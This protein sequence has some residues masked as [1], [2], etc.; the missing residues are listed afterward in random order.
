MGMTP[1]RRDFVAMMLG[2]P[3]AYACSRGS[4]TRALPPGSL[5]DTG[6]ARAHAAIRDGAVPTV[7]TWRKQPVVIV[8]GGVAGLSAAWELRLFGDGE[9]SRDFCFIDNC[10]EAN[11]LA[12]TAPGA[13]G[14]VFNV[15]CGVRTTLLDVIAELARIVGKK[16]TPV[17]EPARPGDIKHSLAD[18]TQART[19]LGYTGKVSFA[20]GLARTVE[21]FRAKK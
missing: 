2:A 6:M 13:A 12:C 10:V 3:F 20:E 18:I 8:G 7:T 17:H 14:K 9:Q 11:L 16:V 21:W 1:S 15:A 19:I 5:I 4:T